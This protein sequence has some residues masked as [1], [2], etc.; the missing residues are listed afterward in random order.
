MPALRAANP[1]GIY[2]ASQLFHSALI[3]SP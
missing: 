1:C 2:F 3:S